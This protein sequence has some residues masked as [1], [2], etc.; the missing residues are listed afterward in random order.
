[1]LLDLAGRVAVVIEDYRRFYDDPIAVSA[2]D[3]VIPDAERKTDLFGWIWCAGP[4]GRGGWTPLQWIDRSVVPWRMIRDF[5]ALE[6][7]VVKGERLALLYSE[8]GF[9]MARTEDGRIGWAPQ[10]VLK[11]IE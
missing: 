8:S 1:M 6:L 9:V 3:I 5:N 4:D 2:G 7:T 10:G 11:L